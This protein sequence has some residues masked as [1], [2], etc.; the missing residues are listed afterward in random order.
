MPKT[1][2]SPEVAGRAFE[3]GA[4]QALR[5]NMRTSRI[6]YGAEGNTA[7]WGLCEAGPERG[8]RSESEGERNGQPI[9][10]CVWHILEYGGSSP[11][12]RCGRL[13]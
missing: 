12:S 2:G 7:N 6:L 13:D 1:R 5:A 11:R 3:S 4:K 10:V 9:T 8:L